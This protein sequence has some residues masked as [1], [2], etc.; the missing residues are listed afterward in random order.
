MQLL[1]RAG[2][3]PDLFKELYRGKYGKWQ[4]PDT[5]PFFFNLSHAHDCVVAV[6][7][8]RGPVGIDVENIRRIDWRAFRDAFTSTEQN[9]L[10]H[11]SDADHEFFML[12]TR[13]E[14]L[15]KM[16]GTGLQVPLN[17][18]SVSSEEG[19]IEE[20]NVTGYFHQVPIAGYACHTCSGF[21]DESIS[22]DEVTH[23]Q[24]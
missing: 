12:W 17:H 19:R 22:I 10:R 13:K 5:L 2:L 3:A 1:Q 23:L 18:V 14:S 15:L 20:A 6:A 16:Q 4:L 8:T 11:A 7:S 24:I 9:T 21:P